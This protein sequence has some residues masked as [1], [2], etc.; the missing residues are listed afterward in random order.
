M[1]KKV[2]AENNQTVD[3][4][5][6]AKELLYDITWQTMIPVGIA[7]VDVNKWYDSI[8]YAI[9]SFIVCSFSVTSILVQSMLKAIPQIKFS[10]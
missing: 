10:L 5:G 6:L 9:T 3:G 2:F 8:A 4:S 7:S 1:T